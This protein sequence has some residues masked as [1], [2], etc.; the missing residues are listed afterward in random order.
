[1][2]QI[3]RYPDR[4]CE[5][6]STY[7]SLA[8]AS[9]GQCFFIAILGPPP[10]SAL[11]HLGCE[12]CPDG[13]GSGTGIGVGRCQCWGVGA[14]RER[15]TRPAT[16][17]CATA[18]SC[19]GARSRCGSRLKPLLDGALH[20]CVGLS[21]TRQWWQRRRCAP[22]TGS[23]CGRP[24]GWSAPSLLSLA[25]HYP[26]Q[27]TQRCR[28]AADT[29]ARQGCRRSP[30]FGSVDRQHGPALGEAVRRRA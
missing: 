4:P 6:P 26:F 3:L 13:L 5:T 28:A 10:L 9:S 19:A 29:T 27:I 16:G 12:G 23:R 14:G 22:C 24:K 2:R 21:P 20:R 1:M 8:K 11:V 17:Q 30:R 7:R 25:L 15:G 18:L